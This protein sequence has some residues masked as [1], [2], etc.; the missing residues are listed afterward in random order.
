M[1]AIDIL[2]LLRSYEASENFSTGRLR[3]MVCEHHPTSQSSVRGHLF[4]GEK[5]PITLM[6]TQMSINDVKHINF[7]MIVDKVICIL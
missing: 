6:V 2:C 7:N 5:K 4:C 3:Y 1:K